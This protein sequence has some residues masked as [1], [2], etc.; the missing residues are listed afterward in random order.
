MKILVVEDEIRIRE[1]I[2]KLVQK[3]NREYEI[4]GEAENGK[5]GLLL[6][7]S[8]KPDIVITDIRMPQMDGLEMLQQMHA[9]GLS[10]KAIVLSAYSEFEY[11]RQAMK[12][13]VTEYLLKPLTIDAFA[14]ALENVR[15]QIEKEHL[16]KPEQVG[17]KEQVLRDILSGELKIEEE[18]LEYLQNKYSIE[19]QSPFILICVYLGYHYREELTKTKKTLTHMWS[20]TPDVSFCILESEYRKSLIIV[21]YNNRKDTARLERWLQYQ[22][23]NNRVWKAGFGWVE[24]ENIQELKAKFD[25]LYPYM[26]WNIALDE[27]ILVSYPKI[28]QIQTMPCIYPIELENG[29][30]AAICAYEWEMMEKIINTFHKHF[31]NG[32]IYEPK[33]IKECYV[34]FMWTII[35]I[36]KEIG[37]LDHKNLEQEKLLELIMGSKSREELVWGMKKLTSLLR[38]PQEEE[39]AVTHLTVKRAKEMIREYYQTGITLEEIAVRLNITPEYL[40]TQFHKEVGVNFS[41]YIRNYRMN[42]A[43]ELLCGTQL[44][45]YEIAEKVG[46][47]DPKYFSRVFKEHTGQLPA[48]YRKAYK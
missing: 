46:Y 25:A 20:A 3:L 16:I 29:I 17:T 45:L 36:S 34:R 23:L 8:L 2:V 14:G 48:E 31:N 44:K 43:K 12:L 19:T 37:C 42:K 11:A 1:G 30:K 6:A 35:G 33:R 15:F 24:S 13:G 32:K 5:E 41:T 38:Q 9:E 26:D 47:S 7:R 27:E 18:I 22:I 10:V 21:L 4:T 28:T 40:G 39:N